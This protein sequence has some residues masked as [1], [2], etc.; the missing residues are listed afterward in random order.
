MKRH[1]VVWSTVVGVL[2]LVVGSAPICLG[3]ATSTGTSAANQYLV[4]TFVDSHGQQI[5]VIAAGGE[6]PEVA[7]EVVD[8]PLPDVVMGIGVLS[9]VPAFDWSY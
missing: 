1:M 7:A 6:P 5:D 2:L 8:V 3:Q 9:D 4:T